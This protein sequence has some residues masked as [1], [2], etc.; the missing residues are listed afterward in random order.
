MWIPRIT[1]RALMVVIVGVGML[2]WTAWAWRRSSWC[3][4]K[5]KQ[6]AQ[7]ESREAVF[8]SAI[9]IRTTECRAAVDAAR[10]D[11][12][13]FAFN[14]WSDE[15]ARVEDGAR[16][17]RE[18][19]AYATRMKTAYLRAAWRPWEALPSES[20]LPPV[21]ER[22]RVSYQRNNRRATALRPR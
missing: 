2:I 13:Y 20:P 21:V 1:I 7:Y 5:A 17:A 22:A 19:M 15:L 4:S 9:E 10:E 16:E 11:Q 18:V 12:A 3:M 8:V 6:F 14:E